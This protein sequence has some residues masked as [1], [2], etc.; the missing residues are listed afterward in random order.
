MSKTDMDNDMISVTQKINSLGYHTIW[1]CSGTV[2][3]HPGQDATMLRSRVGFLCYN[4]SNKQVENLQNTAVSCGLHTMLSHN[5]LD[6]FT[7]D[8]YIPIV[9]KDGECD[10]DNER[11]K[12]KV[13]TSNMKIYFETK[14]DDEI[15]KVHGG[16]VELSDKRKRS[17]WNNFVSVLAPN[18]NI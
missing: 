9:G 16:V 14:T 2:A 15:K 17:I 4:I 5:S 12:K 13:D 7:I 8:I 1:S 10:L 6:G 18:E 3:D 11:Y